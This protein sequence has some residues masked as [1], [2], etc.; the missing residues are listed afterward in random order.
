MRNEQLLHI[1]D[2]KA[3][4]LDRVLSQV[5]QLVQIFAHHNSRANIL[6]IGAGT[7]ACTASVL[8]TL[9]G[10]ESG[11]ALLFSHYTY[12]DIS[13]ELF[14]DARKHFSAWGDLISYTEL[15]ITIETQEPS[16][17]DGTAYHV[18]ASQ[19][20]RKT[21]NIERSLKMSA[22]CLNPV[23]DLSWLRPPKT[24]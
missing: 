8:S 23:A 21:R 11:V 1:Y 10:G 16:I 24:Q 12:T 2:E 7:G 22:S 3:L 20:L 5:A 4:R 9:G 14:E 13:S 17:K 15:D 18:V 19:V 6:E